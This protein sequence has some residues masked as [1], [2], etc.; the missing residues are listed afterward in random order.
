MSVGRR[1]RHM[2][3]KK[4]LERRN[5]GKE[6]YANEGYSHTQY[7]AVAHT[8]DTD[9]QKLEMVLTQS[10]EDSN[11]PVEDTFNQ[12]T[13]LLATASLSLRC[14]SGTTIYRERTICFRP[15]NH[16]QVCVS[17]SSVMGSM[18]PNVSY[19]VQV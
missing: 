10:E 15:C 14:L 2:K 11:E 6:T 1:R 17:C 16:A 18:G 3:K 5:S 7:S 19:R 4:K 13:S 9:L 12:E 8:M